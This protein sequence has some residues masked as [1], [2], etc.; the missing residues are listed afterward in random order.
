[1]TISLEAWDGVFTKKSIQEILNMIEFI[2]GKECQIYKLLSTAP[3]IEKNRNVS[4]KNKNLIIYLCPECNTRMLLTPINTSRCN[5]VG[6]DNKLMWWCPNPECNNTI[7][8]PN[9]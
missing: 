3:P 8:V 1:M 9:A 7:E 2:E 5:Q 6:G 4:E